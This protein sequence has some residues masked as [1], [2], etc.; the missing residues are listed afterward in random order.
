MSPH[1]LYD[2]MG[3]FGEVEELYIGGLTQPARDD[4]NRELPHVAHPRVTS[5]IMDLGSV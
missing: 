2:I 3:A 5:L 1:V 4:E